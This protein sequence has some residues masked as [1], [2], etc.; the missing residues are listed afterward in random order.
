MA[1]PTALPSML[2]AW[3]HPMHA[4]QPMLLVGQQPAHMRVS[5]FQGSVFYSVEICT[6]S[7]GDRQEVD[8]RVNHE[9]AAV[10]AKRFLRHHDGGR[11]HQVHPWRACGVALKTLRSLQALTK[12]LL[13]TNNVAGHQKKNPKETRISLLGTGGHALRCLRFLCWCLWCFFLCFLWWCFS[14]S[15]PSSPS[16]SHPLSPQ[17]IISCSTSSVLQLCRVVCEDNGGQHSCRRLHPQSPAR[18]PGL[19]LQSPKRCKGR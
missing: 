7:C 14:R 9:Q 3:Q 11:V 4:H 1:V 10:N 12:T 6:R 16:S 8:A 18:C 17:L 19:R 15:P 2:I 5:G 13:S